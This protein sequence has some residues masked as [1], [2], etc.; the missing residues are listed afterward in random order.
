MF[1]AS[2]PDEDRQFLEFHEGLGNSQKAE[3]AWLERR[4]AETGNE[5]YRYE[6]VDV[7]DFQLEDRTSGTFSSS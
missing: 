3:V 7:R 4:L 1:L 2:L 6:E 5:G